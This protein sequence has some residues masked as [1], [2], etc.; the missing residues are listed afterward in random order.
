MLIVGGHPRG[1]DQA[2]AGVSCALYPG[3]GPAMVFDLNTCEVQNRGW[4]P[5]AKAEY[6]VPEKVTAIIGGRLVTGLN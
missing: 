4:N 1:N 2:T 3:P 5:E 6:Q